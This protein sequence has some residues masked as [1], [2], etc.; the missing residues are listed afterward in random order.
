MDIIAHISIA[1]IMLWHNDEVTIT[2]YGEHA[3]QG[4]LSL[5]DMT[6]AYDVTIIIKEKSVILFQ[7]GTNLSVF[8]NISNDKNIGKLKLNLLIK[9]WL[10]EW[11]QCSWMIS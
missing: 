10:F 7:S 6:V 8:I 11:P 4:L 5:L 2:C 3:N 9:R 1:V